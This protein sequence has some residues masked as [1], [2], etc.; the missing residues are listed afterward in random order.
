MTVRQLPSF[1]FRSASDYVTAMA[2]I[3]ARYDPVLGVGL[4][5][6]LE[7]LQVFHIFTS[8]W[9]TLSLRRPRGLDHRLHARPDAAAV[10]P[11]ERDPGRPAGAVLRPRRCPTGRR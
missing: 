6:A 10:A 11:V 9:F 5:N 3:H 4:V 7:R 1:A 8:T 2:E